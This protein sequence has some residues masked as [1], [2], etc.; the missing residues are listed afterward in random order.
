VVIGHA[1]LSANCALIRRRLQITPK[2]SNVSWLPHM[3]DMGLVG[4]YLV[5]LTIGGDFSSREFRC[6]NSLDTRSTAPALN[7]LATRQDTTP[8]NTTGIF[9]SPLA[10]AKDPSSW[11][12]L[13]SQYGATMTQGPDFA[14]RLCAMRFGGGSLARTSARLVG[15]NAALDLSSLRSCLNASERVQVD[16]LRLFAETFRDLH[17]WNPDS[18]RAGYGLAESVVYV[19]DGPL[20]VLELDRTQLEVFGK[21]VL[22]G[23]GGGCENANATRVS[24]CGD[25]VVDGDEHK[26]STVHNPIV[27]IVNPDTRVECPHDTVG[28]VWVKGT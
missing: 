27:K 26:T 16:T 3:H 22:A 23:V 21:V 24:S 2:D 4:A 28:E 10:F 1:Q 9:Y 19:C 25:V 12:R 14:Y 11:M 13:A 7:V 15:K 8:A 20:E 18:M 17:G 6:A 5:P